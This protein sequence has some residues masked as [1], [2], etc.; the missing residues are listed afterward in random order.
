MED[1]RAVRAI[2]R[3]TESEP[4]RVHF[5]PVTPLLIGLIY[6]PEGHPI[7]NELEE[8]NPNISL[9]ALRE[10]FKKARHVRLRVLKH[11]L[12]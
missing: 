6:Q 2:P 12:S 8:L 11:L 9:L 3:L 4:V 7:V 10:S 5:D 1:L